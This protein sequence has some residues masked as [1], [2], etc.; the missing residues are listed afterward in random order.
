MWVLLRYFICSSNMPSNV[1][2]GIHDV[3]EVDETV[4]SDPFFNRKL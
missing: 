2:F 4:Y 3:D 1:L